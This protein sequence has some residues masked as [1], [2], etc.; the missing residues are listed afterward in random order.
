MDP[1][2]DAAGGVNG[3]DVAVGNSNTADSVFALFEKLVAEGKTIVMVTHDGELADRVMRKVTLAD[4]VIVSDTML[5]QVNG[6]ASQAIHE[7]ENDSV[8]GDGETG[9]A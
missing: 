8:T 4:G 5:R 7:N 9:H 3:L 1:S 2:E 6:A